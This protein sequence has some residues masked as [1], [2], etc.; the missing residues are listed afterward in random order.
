MGIGQSVS[1]WLRSLGYDAVHLNDES[2]YKM[3]DGDIVKKAIK[4]RRVIITTDMDFGQLLA[5]NRSLNVS[6]IQFRTSTF[7]PFDIKNKIEEFFNE[8][9]DQ[10]EEHFIVT[11]E[12]TRIRHRKLPID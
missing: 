10:L 1:A 2:L 7:T 5:F 12:D 6:V 11:I 8:F 3:E 9:G 4:E